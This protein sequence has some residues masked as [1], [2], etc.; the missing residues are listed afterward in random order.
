[1]LK[2]F[3]DNNLVNYVDKDVSDWKDAIQVSCS[4]LLDQGTINQTY[5]DEIIDC[6]QE[7]GPYIVIIPQVAMPH[8]SEQSAGVFGTAISFTKFKTPVIFENT[9]DDEI[10][11]ASL[12]FTLAA[13]NPDEH[14]KNIQNLSELLMI[15]GLVDDLVA[16][17]NVEDY[18]IIMNKYNI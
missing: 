8:S 15:D 3:Y 12:F 4:D 2:Y 1:M 6:V 16:T 18:Q 17:K 7:H 5:V 9:L 14:M 13:K 10:K 11:E